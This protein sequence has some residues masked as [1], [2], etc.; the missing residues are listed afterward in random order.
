MG[1]GRY[2]CMFVVGDPGPLFSLSLSHTHTLSFFLSLFPATLSLSLSLSLFLSSLSLSSLSLSCSL[3]FLSLSLSLS[4]SLYI[5]NSVCRYRCILVVGE[6]QER[7]KVWLDV[8]PPHHFLPEVLI[9]GG[10]G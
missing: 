5:R 10:R 8:P 1:W 3:S 4:L 6:S 7:I 9:A 2:R